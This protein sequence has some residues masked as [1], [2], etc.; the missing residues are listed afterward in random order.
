LPFSWDAATLARADLWNLVTDAG[1]L[2]LVFRP[3]GTEGYDD[4]AKSALRY[5][6]FGV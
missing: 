3:G 1:R 4:L 6:A 5:E 2:D